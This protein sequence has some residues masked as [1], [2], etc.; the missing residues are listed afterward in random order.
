M[1]VIIG[2]PPVEAGEPEPD[3]EAEP[4]GLEALMVVRAAESEA[5]VGPA[6]M[7]TGIADKRVDRSL[8][9]RVV[10]SAE[11]VLVVRSVPMSV[12]LHTAEEV[13]ER[14]QPTVYCLENGC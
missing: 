7:V 3:E 12:A 13:P 8:P 2:M 4:V 10:V 5:L 9:V 1:A 6:V 14:T 11:E